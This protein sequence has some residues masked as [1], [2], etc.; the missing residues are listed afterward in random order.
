MKTKLIL[1][2]TKKIIKT[3]KIIFF[4]NLIRQN[5]EPELLNHLNFKVNKPYG[6]EAEIIKKNFSQLSIVHKKF[7]KLLTIKLNNFQHSIDR[8]R[9][10][11]VY[12]FGAWLRFYLDNV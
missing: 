3:D 4:N 10:I 12:C 8:G 2:P 5:I 9:K 1:Y 7:L 11:L 6:L